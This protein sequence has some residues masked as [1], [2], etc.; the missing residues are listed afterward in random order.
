MR[1]I[2]AK[3][4]LPVPV[5]IAI[6]PVA[7]AV[8]ASA[9]MRGPAMLNRVESM[10]KTSTAKKAALNRPS[11]PSSRRRVPVMSLGFSAGPL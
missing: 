10:A 6:Q 1:P 5:I 9:R 4:M 7:R 2:S 11:V 3:S 8:V